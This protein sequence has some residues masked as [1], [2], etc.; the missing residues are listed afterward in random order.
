[1]KRRKRKP[2]TQFELGY[3]NEAF[4]LTGEIMATPAALPTPMAQDAA[5]Q[6][7]LFIGKNDQPSAAQAPS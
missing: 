3:K 5:N 6:L 7:A 2:V 1:M 4:K